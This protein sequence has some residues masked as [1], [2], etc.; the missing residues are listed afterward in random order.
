MLNALVDFGSDDGF[1]GSLG[2]GIGIA[3]VKYDVTTDPFTYFDRRTNT[4]FTVDGGSFS[5]SDS[6]MAWQ[7]IAEVRYPLTNNI[8]IGLKG[9]YFQT[10]RLEMSD[11]FIGSGDRFRTKWRSTSLLASLVEKKLLEV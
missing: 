6:A 9:R 7:G 5:D 2:G 4:Q 11:D 3:G 8:D 1:Q 10:M